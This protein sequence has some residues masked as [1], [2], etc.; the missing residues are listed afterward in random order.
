MLEDGDA[1]P[2]SARQNGRSEQVNLLLTPE[3]KVVL[4]ARSRAK[5]FRGISDYIRV[6]VLAEKM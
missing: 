5:G 6:S 4:E 2:I 1:P 3:E